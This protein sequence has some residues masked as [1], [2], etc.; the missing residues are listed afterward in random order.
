MNREIIKPNK[1]IS[2]GENTPKQPLKQQRIQLK[3]PEW[4][5]HEKDEKDEKDEKTSS[6]EKLHPLSLSQP[7]PKRSR[8]HVIIFPPKDF[9]LIKKKPMLMLSQFLF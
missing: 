5:T 3:L 2:C 1:I 8:P 4:I 6:C 9:E 7:L